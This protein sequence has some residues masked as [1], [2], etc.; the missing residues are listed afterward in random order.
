M[1]IHA[2]QTNIISKNPSH[3][4]NMA[5][6]LHNRVG[7]ISLPLAKKIPSLRSWLGVFYQGNAGGSA[8]QRFIR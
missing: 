8:S 6:I 5:L 1:E 3:F 2:K 4:H 7:I